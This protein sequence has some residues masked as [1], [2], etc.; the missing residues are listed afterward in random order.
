[1]RQFGEGKVEKNKT[2]DTEEKAPNPLLKD[3][4][5]EP[6]ISTNNR[7]TNLA[8]LENQNN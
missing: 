2:T 6:S 5:T 3:G 4:D 8:K 1:M 7:E